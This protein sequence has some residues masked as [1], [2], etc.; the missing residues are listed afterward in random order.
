MNEKGCK[1]NHSDRAGPFRM[2][3]W[4][5]MGSRSLPQHTR[6]VSVRSV[7]TAGSRAGSQFPSPGNGTGVSRVTA[8]SCQS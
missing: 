1:D 2:S 5:L 6:A 4:R 7:P 3:A 8:R